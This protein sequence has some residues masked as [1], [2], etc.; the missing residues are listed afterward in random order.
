MNQQFDYFNQPEL[1]YLILCNPDKSELYSLSLAYETKM[2]V[3]FNTLSEFT[4]VFPQSIDGGQIVLDAYEYIQNKRLVLVE[5][6]GYFQITNAQENSEGNVP[7][8]IVECKSLEVE[9]I[10]KRL[11]NYGGTLKLYDIIS[12]EGTILQDMIDLAPNYSVGT[13]SAE[14]LTKY[15][16]FDVSDTNIYNFLL[17]DVSNAF[18]CVFEFD[19]FLRRINVYSIADATGQSDIFLSYDN[20]ISKASFSEK[21]D[22]ITTALSVFGAGNLNINL[23]NPLGTSYIYDFNY[24]K[25]TNWMSQGLV[26]AITAWEALVDTKQLE[27]ANELT[28]L[29]TYNGELLDLQSELAVLNS[30]YLALEG[31]QKTRIQNNLPY[32]DITA[33]MTSKQ[34]EIDAQQV[35]ISNKEMQIDDVTTELQTINAEVSFDENFTPLQ[36]LELNNFIYENT[37]QNEN[38]IQTDSMTLVEVQASAQSL[39]NQ[40]KTVLERVSRPRY[41]IDMELVNYTTLPE[42]EVFTT[43]TE[44]GTNVV[45]ELK[46]GTYITTVVLEIN[47]QFDD[48]SSFSLSL[49]N[50][51]RLDNGNF[52][53]SDLLGQV[54]KTGSAVSFDSTSW[55]NWTNDYKNEVTTFINSNL[56]ATLNNIISNGEQEIL[57][58]QNGLRARN[59]NGLGGY[60][61][62]QAWLVNNVLA[63][64]DDG[65]QTAKLALGEINTPGGGT[66]FGLVGDYIVGRIL[67]GNTLSIANEANNFV[68]DQTGATLNNAKFTLATTNT[69]I[70]ID[71]T[72]LNSFVIQKNEGGTFVNKF[73]VDNTGNVNFSGTLSGATGTFSGTLSANVG[74]IG[75]LVIDSQGLKTADGVNYLRGNGDLKWGGLNISGGSATFTGNIYADKLVGAVSYTQ[76][77]DIPATKITSGTMSGNRIFGG[78]ATLASITPVS[79]SLNINGTVSV[80]GSLLAT[81]ITANNS[82]YSNQYYAPAGTGVSGNLVVLIPGGGSRTLRFSGGICYGLV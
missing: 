54:V 78:G 60:N 42:F 76:L 47:I 7:L 20:V 6:Y 82:I 3:R 40:A 72:S 32:S 68:L 57:I 48:P 70:N 13:I 45:C 71:P 77:T 21:S 49:S 27:Y 55:S 50:R 61:P 62:K 36:L 63:F 51:L 79:G 53:Y 41:E 52:T 65:F 66:A 56:D 81:S 43:Q 15:R 24:Y 34:S 33:L 17:V 44:V 39:Y 73:W 19:S 59:S 38:I 29:S 28:L 16:T 30:Q 69:I 80:I 25:S 46:D 26:N 75:T 64:S 5:G 11:T 12:P 31:I 23:V 18:E 10:Q 8:M 14:L 37:Y 35:L 2:S 58:N 74:N 22:E 1:P 67:A 4:F 9:L